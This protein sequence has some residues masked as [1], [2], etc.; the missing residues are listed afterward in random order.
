MKVDPI[1]KSAGR[2]LVRSAILATAALPFALGAKP[3]AA[4]ESR[5]YV[6]SWFATATTQDF[7]TDCPA[8]AK[9]GVIA[10]EAGPRRRDVALVDGKPVSTRSHPAAV[11]EDP[12]L[13]QIQGK[14]AY[15]FDLGGPAK[16]KFTDP[17]TGLKVDNQLWR[18]IGCHPNFAQRPPPEMPYTEALGWAA[19]I[20]SSPGWALTITGE[21][22]SKDGPVKIVVQRTVR[23]L[24]R[25]AEFNVRKNVTY[26]L[27]PAP[28]SSNELQGEIKEG[29]LTVKSGNVFMLADFPFYTQIDISNTKMRMGTEADGNIAGIWG[30]HTDWH[31]WVYLYTAR[32]A[33]ADPVAFYW[34]LQ[35]NAD[36]DPDPVTGQ[37]LKI[38][39]AWRVQA[40]PAFLADPSGKIVATATSKPL[41]GIVQQTNT[42]D[43]AKQAGDQQASAKN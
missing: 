23:H 13:E 43:Y 39:T 19:L 7:N 8:T 38:S 5:G 31:A 35:R 21:D 40:V 37:N 14:F 34:N 20:D 6:I 24:E 9:A 33:V 29:I 3:A 18:S 17:E 10:D 30:G 41:G 42:I 25:D 1:R 15:G 22:L 36:A 2:M 4:L 16:N 28:R 11:Q 26:V 32:P 27:D 12:K